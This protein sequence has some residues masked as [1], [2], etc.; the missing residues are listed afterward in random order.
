[1]QIG[2]PRVMEKIGPNNLFGGG[3]ECVAVIS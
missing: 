2:G 3:Y 1:M